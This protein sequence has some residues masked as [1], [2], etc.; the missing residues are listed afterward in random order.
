MVLGNDIIK[1]KNLKF[2]NIS[3]GLPRV[4]V[5]CQDNVTLSV[6]YNSDSLTI[7]LPR[8]QI[9][10]G[11]YESNGKFYSELLVPYDGIAANTYRS[12]TETF[13]KLVK[14]DRRF[15]HC[16]FSGHISKSQ[17]DCACLR[18]KLP[19]NRSQVLTDVWDSNGKRLSLSSYVKGVSIV[20]IVSIEYVYVVEN[21][22]GCNLLL[23]QVVVVS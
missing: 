11:L 2:D 18:V 21:V 12:L 15:E 7:Q 4:I 1:A 13:E 22:I 16:F 17:Q 8:C 19:Q 14:R 10:E 3:L 23:Q 6:M 5:H 20:P 9:F